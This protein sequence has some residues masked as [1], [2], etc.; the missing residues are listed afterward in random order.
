MHCAFDAFFHHCAGHLIWFVDVAVVVIIV[1]AAPARADE[2]CKAAVA[3]FAREQAGRCEFFADVRAD[4]PL[5]YAAHAKILITRKLMA[6]IEVAV[7]HNGEVFIARAARRDALLKTRSAFEVDVEVEEGKALSFRFA[8][9]VFV[10]E[11]FILCLDDGKMF[12]FD[13]QFGNIGDD[14]F[15][16]QGIESLIGKEENVLGEIEV[17]C[18]ECAAHIVVLVPADLDKLLDL[19]DDRVKTALSRHRLAHRVVHFGTAVPKIM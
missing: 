13:L 11:L 9:D 19:V 6:G 16:G 14:G 4:D 5:P 2:F 17:L 3:L 1:R 7:G 12:L 18:R 10:A 15:Y 8:A